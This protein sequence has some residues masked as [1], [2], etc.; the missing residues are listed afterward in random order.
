MK[1]KFLKFAPL[2]IIIVALSSCIKDKGYDNNEYQLLRGTTTGQNVVSVAIR[3]DV[4]DNTSTQA[5]NAFSTLTTFP[6]FVAFTISGGVPAKQDVHIVISIDSNLVNAY[7]TANGTSFANPLPA[8]YTTSGTTVTIPAGQ[9]T[10]YLSLSLIPANFLGATWALGIKILSVDGGYLIAGNGKDQGIAGFTIKNG[11]DGLYNTRINMVGW[12]AYGI[13]DNQTFPRN[14][15]GL[16][17]TGANS[18]VFNDA[19][20]GNAQYGFNPTGGLVSFGA[21]EPEFT[22]DP[23]TNLLASVRNL[24]PND[25]RNRQFRKNTLVSDSRFDPATH[26]VYLAYIFSQ[27]GR[28]DNYVYDTL[29]YQGPRP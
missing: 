9:S 18:V 15:V 23:A 17:T 4:N 11:Y 13:Q 16:Q 12:A 20:T 2:A 27:N 22:F 19:A 6:T 29:I 14:N 3:T 25:G 24:I 5:F 7:N 26:N 10:A 1:N 21:T 8:T 28:P